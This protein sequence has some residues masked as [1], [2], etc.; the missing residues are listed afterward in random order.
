MMS[1]TGENQA[2]AE[3]IKGYYRFQSGIYDLTRWSFLFGRSAIL[4]ALPFAYEEPFHLLEVGCG[5]GRNLALAAKLFPEAKLTGMDVSADML[6][7]ASKRTKHQKRTILLEQPYESQYYSWTNKLDVILFSYSLTMI[8]PQWRSLIAQAYKDLRPGGIIA[9]VDFHD[10][11]VPA[12]K[13]HM[14]NHHVRMDGH[15]LP[16]L[17][18]HFYSEYQEVKTAY[19]GLWQY[20]LY[21]GRKV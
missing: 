4:K 8:N 13:N 10:S 12:F 9:G 5:T 6:A 2:Q 3:K 18:A 15:L 11:Q 19:R 17:E 1:N 14:A 20:V 21:V 16:E 7:L